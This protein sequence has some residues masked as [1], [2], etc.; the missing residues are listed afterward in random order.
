MSFCTLN[1]RRVIRG[2]LTLPRVGRWH[3]DLVVDSPDALRGAVKLSFGDGALAFNGA[4]FRGDVFQETFHCRIVGGSNGLSKDVPAKFYRGVPLR[5]A[6]TDL[7]G[8]VG[9]T[10]SPSSDSAALATLLPKWSRTRGPAGSALQDLAEL[11]GASWRVM[12]NG[13]VWLGRE[14]WPELDFPHQLLRTDPADDRIEIGSDLPLLRPGVVFGGRRV[15]AVVHSFGP[16]RLRAEAWIERDSV[17]D[18]LKASLLAV[19]RAVMSEVDYHKPYPARVIAHD[20]DGTLQVRPDSDRIPGL[21]GVPIRYGLPGVTARVPPGA[22]CMIEFENGDGRTPI[23]TS[24]EP[25]A[26]L[27]L[28]FDGG[29]RKVARVGDT[30]DAGAIAWAVDPAG[31]TLTL[32]YRKPGTV[33]PVPFVTLGLP[34]VKATPPTGQVPLEG[35]IRSG[36]DKLLA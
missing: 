22:R 8:E 27:E 2:S 7:L 24:F 30:T 5:L 23:A 6:L 11:G 13:S 12:P 31:T 9:E 19:V 10:L 28:S 17:F 15:S 21:T 36:A 29:T 18:R 4:I 20:S 32:S 33:A 35:V 3:A 16:D 14:T 34:G 1:E 25:G 26:L